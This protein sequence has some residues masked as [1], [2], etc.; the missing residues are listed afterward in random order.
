[1]LF[2]QRT[3][4]F[5]L[6]GGYRFISFV[7][8]GGKTSLIEWIAAAATGQG[9]RAIIT[10]TTKIYA[11]EPY[12]LMDAYVPRESR[13]ATGPVRVGKAVEEGKLTGI[14]EEEVVRLGAD[15]DMVLIEAD[16]AKGRPLKCPALYEPVIPACSDMIVVVAGLDALGEK[17]DEKVFRWELCQELTGLEGR[18]TITPDL[19]LRFFSDDLLLKQ[20]TRSKFAVALNKCD[21]AGSAEALKV[22][23]QV[24]EKVA[25]AQVLVTSPL[26]GI[27]YSIERVGET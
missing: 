23:R 25:P 8:G 9:K 6:F 18:M 19:F 1:M 3:S 24:A 4:P 12:V 20:V 27:L 2:F 11:K 10:T 26:F 14:S 7:G 13:G 5:D 15:A 21:R 17:V 22:R 16:G